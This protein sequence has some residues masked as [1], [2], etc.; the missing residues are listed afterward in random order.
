MRIGEIK[1]VTKETDIYVKIN[2]DGSGKTSINTGIGFF[3]HMLDA[4]GRH[5]FFDLTVEVKGDLDVDTHHTVEDVGIVIGQALKMAVGDKKG[6]VRYGS[7]TLPMD[8]TLMIAAVDF[9]GRSY[10]RS[11]IEYTVERIGG[12]ETETINEF[13][14]AM[15]N[16]A[17]MNLHLHMLCG[18]NN[19]HIAEASFKALT[20]AISMAVSKDPR[21]TDVLSTKGSL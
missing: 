17:D 6:I 10:Y 4:F 14:L 11:N 21:I 9:S 20:K 8:E 19:H 5:G 1:R 7:C 2:L 18:D 15:A 13:F 3:D 16:N 12:L